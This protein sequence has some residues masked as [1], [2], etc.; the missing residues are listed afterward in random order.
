MHREQRSSSLPV[1]RLRMRK[2]VEGFFYFCA[3]G[4]EIPRFSQ[5]ETCE[6]FAAKPLG[7]VAAAGAS[8]LPSASGAI[9]GQRGDAALS[10]ARAFPWY[11]YCM[12]SHP[13]AAALPSSPPSRRIAAHGR[14]S[15]LDARLRVPS[16]SRACPHPS[17]EPPE[18]GS[19]CR[20]VEEAALPSSHPSA[21]PGHPR[22]DPVLRETEAPLG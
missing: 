3:A 21:S 15:A 6:A 13:R 11:I 1:L 5:L 10:R 20:R 12:I 2:V 19:R 9:R 17:P 7:A 18:P 14:S 8:P 4:G 22:R 16:P